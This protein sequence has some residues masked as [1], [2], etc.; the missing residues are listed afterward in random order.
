MSTAKESKQELYL[1]PEEEEVFWNIIQ[2]D[3]KISS[4]EVKGLL[5][6]EFNL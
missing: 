2:N 1:T 6:G 3:D 5:I 4:D